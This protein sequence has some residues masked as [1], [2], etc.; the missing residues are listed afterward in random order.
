MHEPLHTLN[1]AAM[2]PHLLVMTG[3]GKQKVDVAR[4]DE[5]PIQFTSLPRQAHIQL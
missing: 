5:F 4:L 3:R 2:M 1:N